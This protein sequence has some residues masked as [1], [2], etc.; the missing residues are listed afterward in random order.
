M[1]MMSTCT[2]VGGWAGPFRLVFDG[3]LKYHAWRQ[4]GPYRAHRKIVNTA[5]VG[6]PIVEEDTILFEKS[7]RRYYH[8]VP[9]AQVLSAHI[10]TKSSVS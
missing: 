4:D 10:S 1:L 7:S 6:L 8:L 3:A 9:K 5:D 2:T